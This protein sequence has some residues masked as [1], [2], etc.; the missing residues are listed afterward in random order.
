MTRNKLRFSTGS[1]DFNPEDVYTG[2]QD[3]IYTAM[4]VVVSTSHG[5]ITGKKATENKVAA[6]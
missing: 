4:V 5:V 6:S 2:Y 1:S 3:T